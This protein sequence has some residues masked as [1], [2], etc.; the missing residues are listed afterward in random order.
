[1][2]TL[3]DTNDPK[4][5]ATAAANA[6]QNKYEQYQFVGIVNGKAVHL[7]GGGY[8]LSLFLIDGAEYGNTPDWLTIGR[9]AFKQYIINSITGA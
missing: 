3:P 1:M 6:A 2:I 5:L 4:A 7:I 9:K 8:F